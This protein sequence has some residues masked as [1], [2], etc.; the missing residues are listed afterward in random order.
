MSSTYNP[1]TTFHPSITIPSDGD[2]ETGASVDVPLEAALDNAAWLKNS[3]LVGQNWNAFGVWTGWGALGV[4]VYPHVSWTSA[5]GCWLGG[6]N[7]SGTTWQAYQSFDGVNWSTFGNNPTSNATP[8]FFKT[9]KTTGDVVAFL[10]RSG[11]LT[12]TIYT[13]NSGTWS[14]ESAVPGSATNL[15]FDAFYFG[16]NLVYMQTHA[17][18]IATVVYSSNNGVSWTAATGIPAA[19]GENTSGATPL[20]SAIGPNLV[21]LFSPNTTDTN[22][23]TSS[24]GQTWT[25]QAL[26]QS[27]D[28]C[29]G[30]GYDSI[31]GLFFLALTTGSTTIVYSS[32]SGTAGTW[33][34]MKTLSYNAQ[35]FAAKDGQLAMMLNVNGVWRMMLSV[36]NGATWGFARCGAL[37]TGG[38]VKGEGNGFVYFDS[39]NYALTQQGGV[40]AA[41]LF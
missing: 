26:P 28:T 15:G 17:A 18:A 40:P 27:G 22:Y 29:V 36:D 34:V 39:T 8:V 9:D 19:F 7:L 10:V 33:T 1:A 37:A 35:G 6:V 16:A 31:S 11:S 13:P 38:V 20:R 4:G 14:V 3:T 25:T 2:D 21:L 32:S 30:A 23:L 41:L 5:Y 24:D 12:S